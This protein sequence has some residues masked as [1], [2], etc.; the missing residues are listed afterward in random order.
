MTGPEVSEIR[1]KDST[2]VL[3]GLL[4]KQL[5]RIT[6]RKKVVGKPFLY[7]TTRAFLLHFGLNSLDDLPAMSEFEEMLQQRMEL[8]EEASLPL[9]DPDELAETPGDQGEEQ[10]M[11]NAPTAEDTDPRT[12]FRKRL[13]PTRPRSKN[14]R[15]RTR[16]T[17]QAQK[18]KQPT[19]NPSPL[20]KK[21]RSRAE[22]A[23]PGVED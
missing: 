1:G 23:G 11:K 8:L 18:P 20:L 6:G 16:K 9:E 3:K 22:T 7:G 12:L 2:A 19:K 5:V 10:G 15:G 17:S 14:R 21:P 13:R 4:D